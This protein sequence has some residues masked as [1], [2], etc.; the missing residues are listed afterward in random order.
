MHWLVTVSIQHPESSA[1]C[2]IWNIISTKNSHPTSSYVW[3]G[4]KFVTYVGVVVVSVWQFVND[5]RIRE[6]LGNQTT[7]TNHKYITALLHHWQN[8]MLNETHDI[9]QCSWFHKLTSTTQHAARLHSQQKQQPSR[10]VTW[11]QSDDYRKKQSTV[12][13]HTKT[14]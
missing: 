14:H 5:G 8:H 9:A 10:H 13:N 11:Y 2:K 3:D 4:A 12:K 1:N 6:W 7:S